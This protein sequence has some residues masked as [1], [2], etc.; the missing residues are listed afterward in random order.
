MITVKII[1]GI[2]GYRPKG[3]L[4][5]EPVYPG[6]DPI[7]LPDELAKELIGKG[8]AVA[9]TVNKAQE[10]K[11]M[12][13]L[14]GE[15]GKKAEGKPEGES[16]EKAEGEPKGEPKSE[17]EGEPKGEPEREPE[18]APGGEGSDTDDKPVYDANTSASE[19]RQLAKTAGIT[20]HFGISKE[21]M[22]EALDAHYGISRDI[23]DGEAP[24]EMSAAAPV[25]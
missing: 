6:G 19:L 7:D 15:T 5:V 14:E 1:Q 13:Q 9:I 4:V 10:S 11:A 20:F 18:N 22:I 3:S 25:V 23:D 16:G 12:N 21:Q 24:P 8:V 2:F 17:P